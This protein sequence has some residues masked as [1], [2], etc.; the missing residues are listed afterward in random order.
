MKGLKLVI[1]ILLVLLSSGVFLQEGSKEILLSKK[2]Q[3]EKEIELTN[4]LLEDTRSKRSNTIS[5]LKLLKKRLQQRN[6][7]IE[8]LGNEVKHLD[9]EISDNEETLN[10]L[11]SDLEK[12][13][14]EYASLIYHAFKNR[15]S[16]LNFMYLLASNDINQFY[17][18]FK[19]LE[20]YKDYRHKQV[21]LIRRLNLVIEHKIISLNRTKREKMNL[22]NMELGERATL[23]RETN[24]TDRVVMILQQQEDE[25][26]KKLTEKEK[27]ARK[28]E[29][30]I[31]ELI[32]NEAK[33]TTFNAL[34]PTDRIISDD[35]SRNMGGLPW[36]TEQGVIT[37][38]YG[39]HPHPVIRNLMVRN[40]G[41]DIGTVPGGTAR[42][43]FKGVVSKVFNIKG[44]NTTVIIRH[45]N[46]YTVYH[47]LV[48][49][50]VRVGEEVETKQ[51]IGEVYSNPDSNE[52]VIHLEIWKELEK[53]NPEKW[54]SN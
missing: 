34:T 45:G 39:E 20:Q 43:I 36:P 30:E 24:E 31:E 41:I 35:F 32:R 18:R 48:N 16:N 47:N 5:E 42:S 4:K 23:L 22:I 14:T 29:S 54:L 28:L 50:K 6:R 21:E 3:I 13:K 26:K 25:L 40:N 12:V 51:I 37:D 9:D 17:I 2:R 11:K 38:R 44:A 7:L 8:E 19:Y 10:S 33:R 53:Q 1:L 27:I 46:Y 52:T 15:D 49:V